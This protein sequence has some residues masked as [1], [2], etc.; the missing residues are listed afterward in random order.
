MNPMR[1]NQPVMHNKEGAAFTYGL[2][3]NRLAN[4]LTHWPISHS[5]GLYDSKELRRNFSYNGCLIC[6]IESHKNFSWEILCTR[7][8]RKSSIHSNLFFRIVC[9]SY[10][11]IKQN[12][13]HMK[14]CRIEV[15]MTLQSCVFPIPVFL[16]SCESKRPSV[17]FYSQLKRGSF[18]YMN[19]CQ[20]KWIFRT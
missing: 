17:R 15:G 2:A 18:L 12:L 10:D 5:E 16:Q 8:H 20:A 9:F 11:G 13:V 14:S 19:F 7:Y 4:G 3:R 1:P 6:R